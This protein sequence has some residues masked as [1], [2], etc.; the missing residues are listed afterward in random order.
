MLTKILLTAA[1]IVGAIVVVPWILRARKARPGPTPPARVED[2]IRCPRCGVY[3]GL[4]D[5][6]ECGLRSTTRQ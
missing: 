3:R 5:P 4:H 1:V 6:C 2:L